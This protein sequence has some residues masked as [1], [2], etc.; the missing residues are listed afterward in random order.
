MKKINEYILESN[1]Y[2]NVLIDREKI[3]K[4]NFSRKQYALIKY[5][6]DNNDSLRSRIYVVEGNK[7][8]NIDEIEEY[9]DLIPEDERGILFVYQE[10]TRM[11]SPKEA[12]FY[13][14]SKIKENKEKETFVYSY[15][16]EGKSKYKSA[17]ITI[18]GDNSELTLSETD[19]KH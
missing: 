14:T 12:V 11:G 17:I 18:T 15:H 9:R 5:L 19:I 10:S 3:N 8:S 6:I 4:Y 1:K 13:N 16:T 7:K 2:V